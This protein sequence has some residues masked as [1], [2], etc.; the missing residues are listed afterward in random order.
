MREKERRFGNAMSASSQQ[1]ACMLADCRD[2]GGG[3][4]VAVL[5]AQ[6]ASHSIAHGGRAGQAFSL[7]ECRA[8]AL[9]TSCKAGCN[10]RPALDSG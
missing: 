1:V 2:G 9:F 6:K 5:S 7:P 10:V 3:G 4:L 8:K